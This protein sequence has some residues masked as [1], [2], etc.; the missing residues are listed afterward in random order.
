MATPTFST[1]SGL[2][3]AQPTLIDVV[4]LPK[5]KVAATKPEVD[6]TFERERWSRDSNFYTHIIGRA[7]LGYDTVDIVRRRPIAEIQVGIHGNRKW[8]PPS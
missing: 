7:R 5:F 6:I 2:D 8:W 3:I 4:R 1:I